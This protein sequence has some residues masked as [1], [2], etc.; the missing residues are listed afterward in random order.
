MLNNQVLLA[1]NSTS[2]FSFNIIYD[3]LVMLRYPFMRNA[4]I[5][6]SAVAILAGAVGY[7]IVSRRSSFA[8]HALSH[9]GFAGA[10]GAVV[11]GLTPLEGLLGFTTVG[12]IVM[13][14]LGKRGELRDS[15]IGIVLSFMLGLGVLFIS[16][17]QG[18]ASEAYS[19]LF[20]QILGISNAS[21]IFTV[22]SAVVLLVVMRLALNLLLF[23]SFDEEVA[24]SQGVPT[25]LISYAF[26]VVVA[27][28]VAVAVQIIGVLLIFSLLV[29]PAA[30]AI[31]MSGRPRIAILASTTIALL[32]TWI[33]LFVG[34]YQP[35]PVSFFITAFGFAFYL[36]TRLKPFADRFVVQS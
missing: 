10:A 32:I 12:A 17:Y 18:Y 36:L 34:F 22:G 27:V 15:Q 1:A 5:A 9:V 8:A 16:L 2:S 13:G 20:G 19:I 35:Y 21:V 6:G 4:F 7:F 3:L 24:N 31:R 26:L 30:A 23:A 11:V 29:T 33:G 25:R 28:T 14:A